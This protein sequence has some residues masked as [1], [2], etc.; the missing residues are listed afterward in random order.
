VTTIVI[1]PGVLYSSFLIE[2]RQRTLFLNGPAGL[3]ELLQMGGFILPFWMASSMEGSHLSGMEQIV[4]RKRSLDCCN[5]FHSLIGHPP[6]WELMNQSRN[7]T[8]DLM[9][10]NDR[11]KPMLP[12]RSIE[13]Y[14]QDRH[15]KEE[16]THLS[17][18][19]GISESQ[20]LYSTQAHDGAGGQGG[21]LVLLQLFLIGWTC[22]RCEHGS[23]FTK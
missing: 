20:W 17:I 14:H 1:H 22:G 18:Q 19:R 21:I 2:R 11:S 3:T 4:C 13:P 8:V 7:W 15:C 10:T 9:R 12:A 16:T 5:G 6:W 23:A